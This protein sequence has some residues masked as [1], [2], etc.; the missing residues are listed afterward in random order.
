[1]N[2]HTLCCGN[3]NMLD[4]GGRGAAPHPAG[5]ITSCMVHARYEVYKMQTLKAPNLGTVGITWPT[6]QGLCRCLCPLAMCTDGHLQDRMPGHALRCCHQPW[7]SPCP[8]P[9]K[10]SPG[11]ALR[12]CSVQ[13]EHSPAGPTQ[14]PLAWGPAAPT[15]PPWVSAPPPASC[16]DCAKSVLPEL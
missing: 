14:E 5:D 1:M 16:V 13:S 7:L 6:N 11:L 4:Y 3:I 9:S 12:P 8:L 15:S 2:I 10:P